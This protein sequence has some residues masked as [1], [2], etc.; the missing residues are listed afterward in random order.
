M[1]LTFILLRGVGL[2]PLRPLPPPLLISASSLPICLIAAIRTISE[3]ESIPRSWKRAKSRGGRDAH[4]YR[5]RS[6]LTISLML[7]VFA[8]SITIP[9]LEYFRWFSSVLKTKISSPANAILSL[10]RARNRIFWMAISIVSV[11]DTRLRYVNV[12]CESRGVTSFQT[13]GYIHC[14]E[15]TGWLNGTRKTY[16][17]CSWRSSGHRAST[18]GRPRGQPKLRVSYSL[19][20]SNVSEGRS[21]NVKSSRTL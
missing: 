1:R 18:R 5:S 10:S 4:T 12:A 17:Q 16:A 14:D 9:S 7:K 6:A 19:T 20:C 2:T 11:M 15:R 3:L 21:A 8:A 13:A